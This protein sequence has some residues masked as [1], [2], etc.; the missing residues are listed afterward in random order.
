MRLAY[1][2][3]LYA[4]IRRAANFVHPQAEGSRREFITGI[5]QLLKYLGSF[6]AAGGEHAARVDTVT[7][8]L[9][10]MKVFF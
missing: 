8:R 2:Q 10:L 9:H 6:P 4:V 5:R 1:D 3:A 7:Q